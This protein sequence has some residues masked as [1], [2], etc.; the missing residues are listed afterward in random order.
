MSNNCSMYLVICKEL[1]SAVQEGTG[2]H[3]VEVPHQDLQSSPLWPR[4]ELSFVLLASTAMESSRRNCWT[5]LT[6]SGSSSGRRRE[7]P[8][9]SWCRSNQS[10]SPCK[11]C[12]WWAS[13]HW[14]PRTSCSRS[15]QQTGGLLALQP[16]CLLYHQESNLAVSSSPLTKIMYRFIDI[17]L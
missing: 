8:P 7:W 15:Q 12:L 14:Y 11:Y 2:H 1:H 17:L 3:S 6:C 16:S 4:L 13:P 5:C 9:C 10:W